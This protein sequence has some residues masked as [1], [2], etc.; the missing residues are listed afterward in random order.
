M[1]IVIAGYHWLHGDA[2]CGCFADV[3]IH[4]RWMTIFDAIALLAMWSLGREGAAQ[5]PIHSDRW[6]PLSNRLLLALSASISIPFATILALNASGGNGESHAVFLD[7]EQWAGKRCPLLEYLGDN[8]ATVSQGHVT[9]ALINRDCHS[10]QTYLRRLA[11]RMSNERLFIVDIL[12]NRTDGFGQYALGFHHFPLQ[13]GV[14]YV[15][16]VP[17]EISLVDGIVVAASRP[18]K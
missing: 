14:A 15:A 1:F 2:D 13:T 5:A 18:P 3:K 11:P 6:L 12:A 9:I 8:A 17:F 16:D 4:P 10:C 7:P